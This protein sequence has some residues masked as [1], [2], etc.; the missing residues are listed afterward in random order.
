[1]KSTTPSPLIVITGP[2]ATGKTLLAAR[3]ARECGGEVISA[4]SRQVYRGMD[5]GSGK[6]L[7]DF[8][9]DGEKVP[10]HL[11]DIAEPGEEY[12]VFAFQQDFLE[13]YKGIISRKNQPVLCGGTGLYIQAAIGGYRLLEV[14]KN[15]ALRKQLSGK[16]M[17]ELTAM[18]KELKPLHNTTDTSDK[19]RLMRA[20]EIEIYQHTH[21]DQILDYPKLDPVIF[22]IWFDRKVLRERITHRL[23]RR[24]EQGMTDEV[25]GLLDQGLRPEQLTFYGLEYRYLTLYVTGEISYDEMIRDLNTAIHQFAKRQMTWFRRMERSGHQIHWMDGDLSMEEKVRYV[26]NHTKGNPGNTGK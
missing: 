22:A 4:D 14:P 11:I 26:L 21:H 9:I 7:T 2:T 17:E 16:S 10:Y 25:Q 15:S 19:D 12:N 1:M 6:D 8:L 23:A 3:V 20:I 5:L 24:L 18:L 13:A